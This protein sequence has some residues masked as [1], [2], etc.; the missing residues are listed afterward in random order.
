MH[1]YL[2]MRA[3]VLKCFCHVVHR[4]VECPLCQNTIWEQKHVGGSPTSPDVTGFDDECSHK[5]V[6]TNL[7]VLTRSPNIELVMTQ[8]R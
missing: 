8:S 2:A 6:K 7:V 5:F 4:S 3:V 1:M